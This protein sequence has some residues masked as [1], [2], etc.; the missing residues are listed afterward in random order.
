MGKLIY[1]STKT[2]DHSVGLSCAFRQWRAASHCHFIHGYALK[3][4]LTFEALTLDKDNWVVDFG[5]LKSFK[6]FLEDLFDHKTLIAEDDPHRTFFE[7]GHH[8]G[9]MDVRFIPAGGMEKFA[10]YI[11][12]VGEGWLNDN[13]YAS[14]CRLVKVEVNEHSGNSAYVRRA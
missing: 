7:K 8:I 3:V 5:S 14:R 4:Q 11:F 6:G 12:E 1:G 9:V 2:Y 13:G 10:E